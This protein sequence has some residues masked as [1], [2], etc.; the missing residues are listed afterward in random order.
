MKFKN[1]IKTLLKNLYLYLNKGNIGFNMFISVTQTEKGT[2]YG[3][4]TD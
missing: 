4:K 1:K 3:L 2:K